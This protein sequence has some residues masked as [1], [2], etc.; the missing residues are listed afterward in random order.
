MKLPIQIKILIAFV[1]VLILYSTTKQLYVSTTTFFNT[2]KGYEFEYTQLEQNQI[3]TFDNNYLIFKD[4]S[5]ITELS[6]ETFIMVT[7]II[8]ENR[9]DGM[10]VAWKWVRENQNVDYTEFT[11]FYADLS[12]FTKERFKENNS[13]ERRKQEIVKQH[14]LLISTFPGILYNYFLSFGTLK[15]KEGFIS[16]ETRLLFNKVDQ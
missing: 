16:D 11:K 2:V 8:F 14:N 3:T 13:I 10:N 15:Y 9:A 4:K 7:Q 12:E 5:N 6:K 1:V